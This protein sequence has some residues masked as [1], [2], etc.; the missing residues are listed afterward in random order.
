MKKL[1]FPK[2]EPNFRLA[3]QAIGSNALDRVCSRA[4]VGGEAVTGL[5]ARA[6]AREM[7]YLERRTP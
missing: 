4:V 6:M 7:G 5:V 1:C 2:K 3:A